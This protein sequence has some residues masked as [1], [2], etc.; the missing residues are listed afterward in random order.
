MAIRIQALEDADVPGAVAAVQQVTQRVPLS[1]NYPYD[2]V[3]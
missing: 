2:F 1:F 3:C